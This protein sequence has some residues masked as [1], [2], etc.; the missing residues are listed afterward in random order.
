MSQFI[1]ENM[2]KEI[3]VSIDEPNSFTDWVNEPSVRDLK[4]DLEDEQLDTDIVDA[5]TALSNW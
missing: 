1:D 2:E 3:D 4:Q 5:G